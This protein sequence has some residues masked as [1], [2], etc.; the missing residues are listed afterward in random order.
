M[1]LCVL[2]FLAPLVLPAQA[3]RTPALPPEPKPEDLGSISGKLLNAVTEEPVRSATFTLFGGAQNY[4]VITDATGKFIF[5]DLA[6][7]R[8]RGLADRP[9]FARSVY[10]GRVL[11]GAEGALT[12]VRGQTLSDLNLHLM[13]QAVITGR[14]SGLDDE[15][16]MGAQVQVLGFTYSL[17]GKAVTPFGSA[18]TNDLGEYRVYGLEPGKYLI[19][20]SARPPIGYAEQGLGRA[21]PRKAEEQYI[22]TYYPGVTDISAGALLEIAP[23]AESRGVNI[24]LARVRSVPIKGRVVKSDLPDGTGQLQVILAS[25]RAPGG[26]VSSLNRTV[27]A[28]PK[29]AFIFLDVPTGTYDLAAISSQSNATYT[30]RL[31]MN[32]GEEPINDL[33]V[34]LGPGFT[35]KGRVRL[36]GEGGALSPTTRVRLNRFE[37]HL[38]P[39][40]APIL[41]VA[42][43]D[44]TFTIPNVGPDRYELQLNPYPPGY[45]LKSIRAANRDV[46]HS[47]L[48]LL[49]GTPATIEIVLSPGAGEISGV[50]QSAAGKPLAN[51]AVVLMPKELEQRDSFS[52]YRVIASNPSGA[53]TLRGIPPG[54]YK[55]FAWEAMPDLRYL[56]PEYVKPFESKSESISIQ[57]RSKQSIQLRALDSE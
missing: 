20:A 30:T 57:E 45:Y 13:P 8:Y 4:S 33:V 10:M 24:R 3:P 32:V 46:M 5:I 34:A 55:L 1:K 2:M 39:R 37:P 53:F 14:V 52:N 50:V 43:A 47:G 54:D 7:G 27:Y 51:A 12:L 15:P 6:P 48:D 29:G 38:S 16:I 19:G 26:V 21:W 18:M 31:Q 11:K 25:R 23:G 41:A 36:E 56:D 28:D 35:L 40:V 17:N 42:E 9:G 49:T 22:T 44:G